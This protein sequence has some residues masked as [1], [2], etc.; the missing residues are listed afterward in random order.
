MTNVDQNLVAAVTAEVLKQTGQAPAVPI[1]EATGDI[2]CIHC[3][4]VVKK[5]DDSPDH[6]NGCDE[7]PAGVHVYRQIFPE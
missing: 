3:G 7:N 5:G 2:E 6:I 1:K 4:T